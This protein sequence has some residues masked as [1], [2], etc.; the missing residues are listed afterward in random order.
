MWYLPRTVWGY[1]QE[2]KHH[3]W[4]IFKFISGKCWMPFWRD[5][6]VDKKK[7]ENRVCKL[8]DRRE[9]R[10]SVWFWTDAVMG[11][12]LHPL[13]LC[14]PCTHREHR[15]PPPSVLPGWRGGGGGTKCEIRGKE[16]S[17]GQT[18][19]FQS[20][21][22]LTFLLTLFAGRANCQRKELG[23]DVGHETL[24]SLISLKISDTKTKNRVRGVIPLFFRIV[25][26]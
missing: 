10:F 3:G 5:H 9:G 16:T 7:S 1:S 13:F 24:S 22:W 23:L 4:S 14:T 17:L 18:Q 8:E 15:Y 19:S 12:G 6:Q 2:E 11:R 20:T 25:T 21:A 26:S